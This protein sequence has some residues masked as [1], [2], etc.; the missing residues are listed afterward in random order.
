MT[1]AGEGIGV[2]G[3]LMG[4]Q[5]ESAVTPRCL[6]R[7]KD[8]PCFKKPGTSGVATNEA[9][10]SYY[11]E[12]WRERWP[13]L[14]ESL[15]NTR[16]NARRWNQFGC[17]TAPKEIPCPGLRSWCDVSDSIP[18]PS[19]S[20]S[21]V[22]DHYP[23]DLAS[24]LAAEALEA[25]PGETVVDLCAAPGGKSLIL[26]EEMKLQGELLL[27]DL[28]RTR[29][30]KLK[31][32]LTDYLPEGGKGFIT[33]T[34]RD[35]AK[36]GMQ[37]KDRFDRILLDAPC[38]SERHVM[39]DAAALAEWTPARPRQLAKREYALLCSALLA[40]KPGGRVVYSTCSIAKAENDDVIE[41]LLK[42]KNEASVERPQPEPAMG[43]PTPFGWQILPDKTG[44]GP[45]YFAI[46]EKARPL[47]T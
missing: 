44:W 3:Q 32:I 10:E 1:S 36:W 5:E 19:F 45:I 25:R 31:G 39:H 13:H 14:K 2:S 38:S 42:R 41:R 34:G 37:N 15:L 30:E 43:E 46:I 33:V 12:I 40:L 23:M 18:E 11:E 7:Q 20:S 4:G 16:R 27:N 9:F 29:R 22:K 24:I 17:Q 28:S 47:Q 6:Q 26:A 21:G 35:A 8:C